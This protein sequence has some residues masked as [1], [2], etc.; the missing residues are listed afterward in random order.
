MIAGHE[1]DDIAN[2]IVFAY[3][4]SVFFLLSGYTMK[5]EYTRDTLNKR[6]SSLMVPYFITCF[7]ILVMNVIN[8]VI[9]DREGSVAVITETIGKDLL[10]TFWA[11][12]AATSFQGIDI[13]GR[14]GAIWFLPAMFFATWIVQAVLRYIPEKKHQ[15]ATAGAIA[16]AGFISNRFFLL[17]LP[18]NQRCLQYLMYYWD[19]E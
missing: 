13:G 1:G 2:K 19:I 18:F 3:H 6:F 16:L 14:I 15:N 5:T 11:S 10:K 9:I 17:P 4:L 8:S 12:G 7:C